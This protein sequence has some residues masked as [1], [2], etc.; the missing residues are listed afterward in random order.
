MYILRLAMVVAMAVGGSQMANAQFGSNTTPSAQRPQAVSAPV[1][2]LLLNGHRVFLSNGGA[3]AGLFPHPFA[4]TQDRGYGML[5]TAMAAS[6]RF[7]LVDSPAKAE[8]VIQIE[9][10]APNG[11]VSGNKVAGASDPLPTFKLTVFDQ[12]THYVLWTVSQ[13]IDPANLQKTHDKN[14]DEALNSLLQEL[15]LAAGPGKE[16]ASR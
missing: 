8:L 14:F 7:E 5:Y 15:L 13:T 11:P 12:P 4:G 16:M 1:P 9:L 3:D 2:A 10:T 6:G